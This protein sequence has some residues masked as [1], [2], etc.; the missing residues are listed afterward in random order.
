MRAQRCPAGYYEMEPDLSLVSLWNLIG[1]I[2]SNSLA[3]SA[4][5]GIFLVVQPKRTE[6]G[7]TVRHKTKY[8]GY[9]RVPGL[10]GLRSGYLRKL[11]MLGVREPTSA[12]PLCICS[13]TSWTHESLRVYGVFFQ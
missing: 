7:K 11:R 5:A 9:A 6:Y 10:L 3:K 2:G 8:N 12:E 13:S 1:S 4:Q